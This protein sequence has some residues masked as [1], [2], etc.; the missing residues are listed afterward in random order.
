MISSIVEFS[1]AID[2]AWTFNIVYSST[3]SP[4]KGFAWFN[5]ELTYIQS[6]TMD[7][8]IVMWLNAGIIEQIDSLNKLPLHYRKIRDSAIE[9][10]IWQESQKTD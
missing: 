8:Y 3:E 9:E 10:W 4:R 5:G 1:K 6:R 7:L 2:K